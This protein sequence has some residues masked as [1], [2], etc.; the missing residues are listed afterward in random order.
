MDSASVGIRQISFQMPE[1]GDE[2][3]SQYGDTVL[4]EYADDGYKK[5][6]K[7]VLDGRLQKVSV[8]NCGTGCRAVYEY[9][10]T[11]DVEISSDC[12]S[13]W[14]RSAPCF[15]WEMKKNK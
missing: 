1:Y 14:A 11:G 13:E 6:T 12:K 7:Y 10:L 9:S 4:I 15:L 2:D 5:T 8:D 3:F